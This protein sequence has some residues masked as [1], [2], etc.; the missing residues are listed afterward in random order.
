MFFFISVF[1][2]FF[3][4]LIVSY[5]FLQNMVF[6]KIYISVCLLILSLSMFLFVFLRVSHLFRCHLY[7]APM[8]VI[9][10]NFSLYPFSSFFCCFL[11]SVCLLSVCFIYLSVFQCFVSHKNDNPPTI[12]D[13][14]KLTLF[15]LPLFFL[16]LQD[17][18]KQV[19]NDISF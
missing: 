6:C 13:L 11:L 15:I 14:K 2:I 4:Y 19:F 7:I 17:K 16:L 1:N 3:F 5:I 10:F 18:P 12:S 8:Y 9:L